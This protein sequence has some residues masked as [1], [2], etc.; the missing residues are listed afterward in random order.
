MQCAR[1][2]RGQGMGKVRPTGTIDCKKGWSRS[3]GEAVRN[4]MVAQKRQMVSE[5]DQRRAR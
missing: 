5:G 2:R 1:D 4:E 3:V